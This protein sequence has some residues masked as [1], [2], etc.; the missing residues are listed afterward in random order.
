MPQLL[1]SV[2]YSPC[3]F[4]LC[5]YHV[6]RLQAAAEYYSLPCPSESDITTALYRAISGQAHLTLK[7][8]LMSDEQ[9]VISTTS[10]VIERNPNLLG[11]FGHG[12]SSTWH[13]KL[14]TQPFSSSIPLQH[15]I[16]N[17]ND[18]DEAIER[19]GTSYSKHQDVMLYNKEGQLTETTI[20]NVILKIDDKYYTPPLECGL[21]D[22]VMRRYLLDK[23]L[24]QERII[25][26]T[27]IQTTKEDSLWL[28][29]AVRG[30]VSAIML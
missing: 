5:D 7:I 25:T 8:R 3:E 15:K 21:L 2:L 27:E 1:T 13:V 12:T 28:C 17:R 24:I 14:D 6:R 19:N 29:N 16:T 18:Y 4:Y 11:P 10:A 9:R 23:H 30:V 20:F 26:L 22:G